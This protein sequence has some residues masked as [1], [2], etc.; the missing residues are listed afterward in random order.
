VTRVAEPEVLD[1]LTRL[2]EKSLVVYEEDEQGRGR[3]H[4]LE[5]VR[6]YAR[7]R[8]LESGDGIAARH[9]DYF[10][11]LAEEARDHLLGRE[12]GEWLERLE[13]EHDNLR[14][15][16]EFCAQDPASG[17]VGLRLAGWLRKF[18][19]IRGYYRE[20]RDRCGAAL[21]HPEAQAPSSERAA[22]LNSAGWLAYRQNDYAASRPLFEE[23]IRVSRSLNDAAGL[24]ASLRGLG[25]LAADLREHA[26]ASAL[27]EESVEL[28]RQLADRRGEAISLNNLGI[29]AEFQGD[30]AAARSL[31][32]QAR[33]IAASA[34][35]RAGMI[36]P[37]GNLGRVAARQGDLPQARSFL[38]EALAL[39]RELGDRPQAASNLEDLAGVEIQSA[40]LG[41]AAR[42]LGAAAALR[43][44]IG[45]PPHPLEQAEHVKR[46]LAA[47]RDAL[48]EVERDAALAAGRSMDWEQAVVYALDGEEQQ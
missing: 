24:A 21:S 22:A 31:F 36:F 41:R 42:L 11:S 38:S 26:L 14:A 40:Q 32:E 30:D 33:G 44:Q 43:E 4:L 28:C 35:D 29:V 19:E 3:Y 7:D 2:V 23:S 10:L 39:C 8:L 15:A 27:T 45:A 46:C 18:W 5:T 16:L 20:G 48:P 37:L 6:Q 12:Q 34:D 9:P 47:V 13:I 1:L 17:A 25:V